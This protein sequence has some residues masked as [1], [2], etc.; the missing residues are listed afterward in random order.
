VR[1]HNSCPYKTTGNIVL[2][3]SGQEDPCK[4]RRHANSPRSNLTAYDKAFR[5]RHEAH[6]V[7]V[8]CET[9]YSIQH[10]ETATQAQQKRI[11]SQ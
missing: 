4:S 3:R 1:D 11:I 10:T 5:N 7:F 2:H 9:L 6:T 8:T